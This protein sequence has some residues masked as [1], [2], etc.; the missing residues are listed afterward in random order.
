[1]FPLASCLSVFPKHDLSSFFFFNVEFY[2]Y[3]HKI[4]IFEELFACLKNSWNY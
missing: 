1:M 2:V 4:C 3:L